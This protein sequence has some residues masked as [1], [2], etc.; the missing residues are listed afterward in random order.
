MDR[1]IAKELLIACEETIA[2]LT[3]AEGVI[4]RIQDDDERRSLMQSL[5]LVI[6]DVLGSIRAPVVLEHPDLVPQ[7]G[8]GNPDASLNEEEQRAASKLGPAD[9]ELIDQTLLAECTSSW[10]KLA[11]IVGAALGTLQE[12]MPGVPDTY[13]AQRVALLVEAGHLESQGNLQ[14]MRFSE[15]RLPSGPGTSTAVSNAAS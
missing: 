3:A 10:R 6:A 14:Y 1:E 13:Y 8:P 11:R 4:R 15:V 2:S 7:V 9:L 12:R 5:A